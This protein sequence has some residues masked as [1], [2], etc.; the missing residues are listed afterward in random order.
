ML[1]RESRNVSVAQSSSPCSAAF[2][3]RTVN[4]EEAVYIFLGFKNDSYNGGYDVTFVLYF[5]TDSS[6]PRRDRS[7]DFLTEEVSY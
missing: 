2:H 6:V 4:R 1:T 3:L 7:K 5:T